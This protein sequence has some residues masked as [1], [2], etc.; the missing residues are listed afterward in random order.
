MPYGPAGKYGKSDS[1]EQSKAD[2][3][4]TEEAKEKGQIVNAVSVADVYGPDQ[5]WNREN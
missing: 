3:Y 4:P 1:H 2:R 5:Q